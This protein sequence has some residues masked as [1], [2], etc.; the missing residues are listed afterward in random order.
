L[1]NNRLGEGAL[2]PDCTKLVVGMLYQVEKLDPT[3]VFRLHQHCLDVLL[4][5]PVSLELTRL[6]HLTPAQEELL[7]GISDIVGMGDFLSWVS[8]DLSNEVGEAVVP[9]ATCPAREDIG[10]AHFLQEK[11]RKWSMIGP[12]ICP[13]VFRWFHK[14]KL[15]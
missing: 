2:N 3:P 11:A 13:L 8:V 14:D 7:Y 12:F 9:V 4:A 15:M 10:P 1:L 6:P 5:G